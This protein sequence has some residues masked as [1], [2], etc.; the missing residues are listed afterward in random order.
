MMM[1]LWKS[2]FVVAISSVSPSS[3][4]SVRWVDLAVTLRRGKTTLLHRTSGTAEPG[5]LLAVLVRG[6]AGEGWRPTHPSPAPSTHLA[7]PER[8]GQIDV[9]GSALGLGYC[10]RRQGR[11][12]FG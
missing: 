1:D 11:V 8:R 12:G 5:K 6:A 10:R 3:A 7:G 4:S 2:L 9:S